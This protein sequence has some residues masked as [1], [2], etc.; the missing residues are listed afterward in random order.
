MKLRLN[1]ATAPQENHRP[2]VAGVVAAGTVALIALL[3][4]SHEAFATWRSNTA[5]RSQTAQFAAQIQRE[6]AQQQELK[7]YF[8]RKDVKQ[9]RDRADFL[10][11]LISE[12]S[13]PWTRIFMDL[14]NTLPPGVRVVSIAPKLVNGRADVE[15]VV[16]ANSDESKLRFLK[17]LENAKNFSEV[18]VDDERTTEQA[19]GGDRITVKL[20]FWYATE[21]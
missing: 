10:N 14:E 13:F 1:V 2:F 3:V 16:G 12:R 6:Q 18:T 9:I 8:E 4:L 21:T 11:S 7:A 20:N 5:I 15:M 17:A 19:N